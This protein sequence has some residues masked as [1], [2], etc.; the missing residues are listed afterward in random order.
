MSD[1]SDFVMF[2]PQFTDEQAVSSLSTNGEA[3]SVTARRVNADFVIKFAS[4]QRHFAPIAINAF[5]ARKL[6]Q[7]LEQEGF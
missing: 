3:V 6:K 5:T 7:L 1:E 2:F 4:R